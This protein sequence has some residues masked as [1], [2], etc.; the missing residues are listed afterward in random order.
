MIAS[1]TVRAG[2]EAHTRRRMERPTAWT[3]ADLLMA[4]RADEE[5]LIGR[6]LSPATVKS[7]V[8][9]VRRFLDWRTGHYGRRTAIGSIAM[10]AGW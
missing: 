1:S 6:G 3:D 7:E 5:W 4:L 10:D 8:T 2:R 9:R